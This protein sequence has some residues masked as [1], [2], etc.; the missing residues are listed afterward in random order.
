VKSLSSDELYEADSRLNSQSSA[1]E[2]DIATRIE[3]QKMIARMKEAEAAHRRAQLEDA[4]MASES[5]AATGSNYTRTQ[6]PVGF[7]GERTTFSTGRVTE[8]AALRNEL[9]ESFASELRSKNNQP[10][11]SLRANGF[12]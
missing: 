6:A 8:K 9:K 12:Q 10:G 7:L 1:S 3:T 2:A 11:S 5:T 4:R